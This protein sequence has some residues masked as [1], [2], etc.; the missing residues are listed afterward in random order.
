MLAAPEHA[1][2]KLLTRKDKEILVAPNMKIQKGM[3]PLSTPDSTIQ[4]GVQTAPALMKPLLEVFTTPIDP[5][6][7]Y[8]PLPIVQPPVTD[9]RAIP[10]VCQAPNQADMG[11]VVTTLKFISVQI[12]ILI[13]FFS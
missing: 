4:I 5:I 3:N 2:P 13:I 11:E 8:S 6:V 10:W 9:T 7:L 1:V 12:I